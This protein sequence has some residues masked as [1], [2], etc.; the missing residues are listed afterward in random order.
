M[1][2]HFNLVSGAAAFFPFF[3]AHASCVIGKSNSLVIASL[4]RYYLSWI[5]TSSAFFYFVSL[6]F[7]FSEFFEIIV[8][9]F[10]GETS[11]I[12]FLQRR[13]FSLF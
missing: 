13:G 12:S 6:D 2:S 5:I 3:I 11:L 7:S 9:S 10:E 4:L 8:R 1:F